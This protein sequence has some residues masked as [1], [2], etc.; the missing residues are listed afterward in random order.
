MLSSLMPFHMCDVIGTTPPLRALP[1]KAS[2]S[3]NF[4]EQMCGASV[5]DDSASDV[6]LGDKML[7]H[8]AQ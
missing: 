5:T 2:L 3:V 6:R 8:T 4:T 7:H 1:R